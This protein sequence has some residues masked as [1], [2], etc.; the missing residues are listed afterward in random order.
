MDL[1]AEGATEQ[2]RIHNDDA[3]R[4]W[5]QQVQCYQTEQSI[6]MLEYI[7][8]LLTIAFRDRMSHAVTFH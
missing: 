4:R 1:P 5:I 3:Q 7:L 8:F 2:H 6:N